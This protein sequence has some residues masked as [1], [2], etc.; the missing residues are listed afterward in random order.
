[1]DVEDERHV[2]PRPRVREDLEEHV[3]RVGLDRLLGVALEGLDRVEDLRGEDQGR[4][5]VRSDIGTSLVEPGDVRV[6]GRSSA[7]FMTRLAHNIIAWCVFRVGL[8]YEAKAREQSTG[9]RPSGGNR[10]DEGRGVE[11]RR[12]IGL[13]VKRPAD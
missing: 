3:G 5:A 13:D 6:V 1:R 12:T 2:L 11:D 4:H 7:A 10:N 9:D 8:R